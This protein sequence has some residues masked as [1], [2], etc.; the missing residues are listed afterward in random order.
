MSSKFQNVPVEEDTRILSEE[1][2]T[3]GKMDVLYQVWS[4][5]GVRAESIIFLN[6]DVESLSDDDVQ[7]I[8]EEHL[9]ELIQEEAGMTISRSDSGFTFV[10]FNFAF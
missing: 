9:K 10:N 2:T 8:V 4:W 3:I 1:E 6:A 7:G 5:D